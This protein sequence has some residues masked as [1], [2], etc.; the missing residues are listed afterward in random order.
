MK[1]FKIQDD[2]RSL[3]TLKV[4]LHWKSFFAI[5]QKF[6][7]LSTEVT[8]YKIQISKI[9]DGGR[10]PSSNSKSWNYHISI[11]NHPILM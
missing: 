4:S 9:Q 6:C 1:I 10:R 3:V 7:A 2:G 8:W 5:T 11:K